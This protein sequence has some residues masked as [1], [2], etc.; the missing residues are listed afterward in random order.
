LKRHRWSIKRIAC[1]TLK[2][3]GEIFTPGPNSTYKASDLT[4]ALIETC[5]RNSSVEQCSKPSSGTMLRRLHRVDEEVFD[6]VFKHLNTQLL[7]KLRPRRKVV[8]ALDYRTL[9]FYG[10]EQPVLVSCSELPGTT[11]GIMFATLSVV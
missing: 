7:G 3:V 9:P 4:K 10:I 2:T 1:R 5:V 6:L 11:L 8:T